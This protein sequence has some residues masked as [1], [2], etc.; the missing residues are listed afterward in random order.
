[1][2]Q[3]PG[4]S[5]ASAGN[6]VAGGLATGVGLL[7]VGATIVKTADACSRPNA[8]PICLRGPSAADSTA[9]AGAP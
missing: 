9:D 8:S 2:G 4:S 6:P 1:M 7:V 5:P 3:G